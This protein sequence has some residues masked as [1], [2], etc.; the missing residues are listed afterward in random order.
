MNIFFR[1]FV[2]ISGHCQVLPRFDKR[3]TDVSVT[4]GHST[5][6]SCTVTEAVCVEWYQ[7]GALKRNSADFKQSYDGREARLQIGEVFL[8]DAGEYTCVAKNSAG[9][10]RDA[11]RLH[12]IGK[13]CACVQ[14]IVGMFGF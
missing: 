4:E 9:E 2:T 8:D 10:Q 6:L 3:L 1:V 11:C 12:V 5:I 7:N 14:C 13:K